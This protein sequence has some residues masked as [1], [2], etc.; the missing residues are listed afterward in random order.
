MCVSWLEGGI[1]ARELGRG[2]V[3]LSASHPQP[4]FEFRIQVLNSIDITKTATSI[5][6]DKGVILAAIQKNPSGG[7]IP[8]MNW[9]VKVRRLRE[10]GD[11][12]VMVV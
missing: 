4:L 9:D 10:K 7:G 2:Y 5:P 12:D 11:D 8:S 3:N 6:S 1:C